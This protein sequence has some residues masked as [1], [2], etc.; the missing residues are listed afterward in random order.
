MEAM[1]GKQSETESQGLMLWD[2]MRGQK[3]V[4]RSGDWESGW[5]PWVSSGPFKKM[6]RENETYKRFIGVMP[7][8]DKREGSSGWQGK[9]SDHGGMMIWQ[10]WE[11]RGKEGGWVEG[12]SVYSLTKSWSGQQGV[13]RKDCPFEESCR[14]KIGPTLVSSGC[15]VTA[16]EVGR[17][18]TEHGFRVANEIFIAVGSFSQLLRTSSRR[19]CP[20]SVAATLLGRF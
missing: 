1:G 16:G 15:S 4:H 9:S 2:F 14:E 13:P 10:V 7:V 6:L 8:K 11:E 17:V 20:S 5:S 12:D 18:G 3:I 19:C